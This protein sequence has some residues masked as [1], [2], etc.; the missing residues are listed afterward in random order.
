MRVK[1][2]SKSAHSQGIGQIR[3]QEAKK[4]FKKSLQII[5]PSPYICALF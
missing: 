2:R 4:L 1:V 5:L 3:R